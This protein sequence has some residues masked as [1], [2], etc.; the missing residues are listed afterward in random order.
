MYPWSKRPGLK[1][2][3]KFYGF[4]FCC[5]RSKAQTVFFGMILTMM[6]LILYRIASS[7]TESPKVSRDNK[8]LLALE[9][10]KKRT[11]ENINEVMLLTQSSE[12]LAWQKEYEGRLMSAAK[13]NVLGSHKFLGSSDNING[14]KSYLLLYNFRTF[15]INLYLYQSVLL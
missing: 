7:D 8:K 15:T 10:M 6:L 2:K 12:H 3:E 4:P 9:K 1:I 11:M 13:K 14:E 5:Y